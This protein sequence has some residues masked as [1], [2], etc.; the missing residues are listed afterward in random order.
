MKTTV[1]YLGG[2]GFEAET[3]GH[4]VRTDLEAGSGGTDAA[5][6]PPELLLA[7][8][9]TCAAFYGLQYLNAHKLPAGELTVEVTAEKAKEPARLGSFRIDVHG[10]EGANAEALKRAVE[11]CLIH[12]T[13][14]NPPSIEVVVKPAVMAS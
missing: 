1:R 3:R 2:V 7:S 4:R 8:L 13:L 6:S 12:N 9:G 14:R 5:M 10:P 11:K